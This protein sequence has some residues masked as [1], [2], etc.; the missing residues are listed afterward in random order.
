[1]KYITKYAAAALGLSMCAALSLK[2]S[3]VTVQE[4]GIDPDEYK[5]V[6]ITSTN[7][8]GP[9]SVYAGLIDLSVDGK[10]TEGFCIDPFHWSIAGP[11]SY[12][13]V[14]LSAAPKPPGPMGAATALKIEQLWQKYYSPSMQ[15]ADA[16]GLQ[17]A[18][19]E[20]VDAAIPGASFTLNSANDYG[21]STFIAWVN[22]HPGA[23]AAD[24]VGLSGAG[25]D[26]VVHRVPDIASTFGLLGFAFV[27]LVGYRKKILH[28]S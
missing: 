3:P 25:Q 5:V 17:I 27:G 20:L 21:A 13:L 15:D 1:M 12:Q 11:Q 4:L 19:W 22:G 26:Y 9:V 14:P 6:D 8:G 10:A 24:L 18:I 2:A 7:I 16:A 23:A 28:R